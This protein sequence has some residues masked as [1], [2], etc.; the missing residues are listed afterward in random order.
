VGGIIH[1]LNPRFTPQQLAWI[2]NHSGDKALFFDSTFLPLIEAIRPSMPQ[3][4]LF[5][6]LVS[7]AEMI[8]NTFGAIS[9][10]AFLAAGD[11]T[12]APPWGDFSEDSACGLFYTSG[13]TGNPKG[14]LYSHRSTMLHALL[15]ASS[16]GMTPADVIMPVVPMFHANCWGMVHIAPIVGASLVLP[17]PALNGGPLHELIESQGVTIAA[18]VPSMWSSLYAHLKET[19]STVPGLKRL[20]TGGSAVSRS[21]IQQFR[22]DFDVEVVSVWGMT[23]TSPSGALNDYLAYPVEDDDAWLSARARAGRF[24]FGV[25]MAIKSDEGTRLPH[26][27]KSAGRLMVR[28]PGIV[29]SYFRSDT[30]ILDEEGYFDTGDIAV[31]HPDSVMQITDRAKDVIK[32][33][34]EWISSIEMEDAVALHPATES[35]AVIGI[36]HP[37][38]EERPLVVIKTKPDAELSA[39]AILAFIADKL[40][41]WW[42]PEEVVFV[43]DLPMGATGKIDKKQLR[44]LFSERFGMISG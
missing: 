11:N 28:G 23:E 42:L 2:V 3:V 29:A 36:P 31:I 40:P 41:K 24:M 27:G 44:I 7:E 8:D 35:C 32:S 6:L 26:D 9:F 18:G 22:D 25:D 43:D 5:V 1:P 39:D 20:I 14:V 34:G 12:P 10:E 30:E 37:K 19:G 16:F 15:A 21:M 38:W 13:T 17:G 4:S 33:G